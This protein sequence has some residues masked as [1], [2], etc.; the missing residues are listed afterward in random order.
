MKYVVTGGA[1]FIGSTFIDEVLRQDKE[2]TVICIDDFSTGFAKNIPQ[3]FNVKVVNVDISTLTSNNE[4]TDKIK[5]E[6]AGADYMLH[7]AAK[8]RVQPSIE[9]PIKFNVL[10]LSRAQEMN[11]RMVNYNN[12]SMY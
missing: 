7:F 4:N 10:G 11:L 2:S 12:F 1:G 9:N 3:S 5:K 6:V 8:A